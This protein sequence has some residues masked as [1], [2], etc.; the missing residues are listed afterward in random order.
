MLILGSKLRFPV[1]D[2]IKLISKN[3]FIGDSFASLPSKEI[4][5]TV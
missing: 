3:W 4:A 1:K 5:M 2:S